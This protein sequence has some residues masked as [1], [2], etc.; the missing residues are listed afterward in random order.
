MFDFK[1][2]MCV[3]SWV[4]NNSLYLQNVR[5]SLLSLCQCGILGKN[6]F[7]EAMLAAATDTP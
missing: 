1:F 3:P 6:V 4:K 7:E 2:G 5:K